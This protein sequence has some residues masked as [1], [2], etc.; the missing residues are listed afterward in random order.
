MGFS[1]KK[2]AGRDATAVEKLDPVTQARLL[3][4]MPTD[5]LPCALAF[6]LAAELNI[7]PSQIGSQA[8]RH[9]IR[10]THCQLG[11]FGYQPRNKIVQPKQ[12]DMPGLEK[13][14]LDVQTDG[15]VTCADIWRIAD[16]F[17]CPKMRVSAACEALKIKIK[18]CQ[19]GAF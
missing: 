5:G 4:K 7:K 3:E 13:A 16:G 14:I 9:D 15:R 10:L 8:D 2:K 1:E 17:N 12:P 6:S 19:L 11:L 18:S